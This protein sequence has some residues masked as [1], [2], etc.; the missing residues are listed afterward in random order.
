M[1]GKRGQHTVG[2]P[3]GI[4][5]AIFLI[6]IFI[7]IAFIAVSHFFDI[8]KCSSVGMFYEELQKEVDEVWV[9]QET[10]GKDFEINLPSGIMK[11][12]F[13][14]LTSDILPEG[15][16]SVLDDYDEISIY[17]Y[18][19][20]NIFLVPGGGACEMQFNNIKHINITKIT[21]TRNPYCVDVSRDLVLKKGF[22]DKFV[23]IE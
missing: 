19:E 16:A 23:I 7:V 10:A 13:A 14:N 17:K 8:G 9:S 3:F 21:E 20:A 5:F 22:Y 4:I 2:L 11:V 12:C 6:V 18:Q 1:R 15:D